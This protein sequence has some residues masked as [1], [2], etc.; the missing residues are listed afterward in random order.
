[1]NTIHQPNN[2]DALDGAIRHPIQQEVV[3][4]RPSSGS[5]CSL[6]FVNSQWLPKEKAFSKK[7]ALDVLDFARR[8]QRTDKELFAFV[9][10]PDAKKQGSVGR[11]PDGRVAI[12]GVSLGF[13]NADGIGSFWTFTDF[14]LNRVTFGDFTGD[15]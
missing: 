11:A 13:T 4:G 14:E 1:M 3:T 6:L 15:F 12:E 9:P 2:S 8:A 10:E 5:V 7:N